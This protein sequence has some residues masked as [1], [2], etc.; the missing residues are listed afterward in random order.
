MKMS[1]GHHS[2]CIS[3]RKNVPFLVI[4]PV[5]IVPKLYGEI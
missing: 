3:L 2:N 1:A 4:V 5:Q